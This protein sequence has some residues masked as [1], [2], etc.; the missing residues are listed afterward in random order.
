[1]TL[2]RRGGGYRLGL[3][4]AVLDA[5]AFEVLVGD[6]TAALERSEHAL[7]ASLAAMAL[8]MWN[9]P[10]LAGTHCITMAAPRAERLEE[11]RARVLEIHV[12]ADL[13]L[14]RHAEVVGEL[15]QAVEETP[16]RQ[17]LV[18]QLM[19][20]LYRSGRHAEA[21]DVYERTGVRST[22][23]GPQPSEELQRLAGQIVRQEPQLRAPTPILDRE[24]RGPSAKWARLGCRDRG[25]ARSWLRPSAVFALVVATDPGVADDDGPVRVALIRMWNPGG[26]GGDD[27]AGWRPFVDGLIAAERRHGVET[28][29]VDLFP[30]RP[31]LGG[32]APGTYD[33]VRRLSARLEAADFDLRFGRSGVTGPN[34]HDVVLEHPDTHFVFL[35]FCCAAR[36][37]WSAPNVTTITPRGQ[38][39]AHLAGYLS[40]LVVERGV[41]I[42]GSTADGFDGSRCIGLRSGAGVGARVR[43]GVRRSLPGVR[44]IRGYT[45]EWDDRS[46]CESFANRQIDEGSTVVFAS[47]GECGLG[48][49]ATAGLRGV[50]AVGASEDRSTLGAHVLGVGNEALRPSHRAERHLVPRG[51]AFRGEDLELGLV[52][53]AVAL[54]GI[55]PDVPPDIR[56]L[57]AE[58]AA[59]LRSEETRRS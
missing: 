4:T 3:G 20:A 31:P 58:E 14:G 7:A 24:N 19:V 11:Q 22:P 2:E 5:Q 54:V 46:I 1:M 23:T 43:Q 41:T 53:D 39:S 55:H 37:L 28:Q 8:G 33:D 15:R 26:P 56:R 17:Q 47:A 59:R 16:Y 9:G 45:F 13:A 57:V 29:F 35:D 40:G 48:A 52:D 6:A 44:I 12:D 38:Q 30:R 10:V 36:D 50:W 18:A 27:E 49:L 32:N 21:L 42:A 51:S 25:W 34:F